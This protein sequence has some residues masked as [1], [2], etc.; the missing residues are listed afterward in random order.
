M[1]IA[2]LADLA[3][4]RSLASAALLFLM[5][6]DE[7]EGMVFVAVG[8]LMHR[9]DLFLAA[10]D[11]LFPAIVILSGVVSLARNWRRAERAELP[12]VE[13]VELAVL[14]QRIGIAR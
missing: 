5:L 1:G 13:T 7:I 12:P 4:K 2:F 3:R 14:T 10:Q 9:V 6:V 11:T 8:V